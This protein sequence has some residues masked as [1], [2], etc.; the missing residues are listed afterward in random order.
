[1]YACILIYSAFRAFT[2]THYQN[3]PLFFYI[4]STVQVI[5]SFKMKLLNRKLC[6][7]TSQAHYIFWIIIIFYISLCLI[8]RAIGVILGKN[9]E[10]SRWTGLSKFITNVI[11]VLNKYIMIYQ[12]KFFNYVRVRLYRRGSVKTEMLKGKNFSSW[13]WKI[14]YF[15]ILFK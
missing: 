5:I 4:P 6:V 12:S 7:I 13:L 14:I 10:G 3:Y 8:K 15:S 9:C 2:S 1:M 11:I